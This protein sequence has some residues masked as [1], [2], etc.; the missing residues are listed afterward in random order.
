[1]LRAIKEKTIRRLA[2]EYEIATL[3]SLGA[4]SQGGLEQKYNE[5]KRFYLVYRR[6]VGLAADQKMMINR[7][8]LERGRIR[9]DDPE[10]VIQSMEEMAREL[11][12]REA[13]EQHQ[14]R[15][16]FH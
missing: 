9:V 14:A 10:A 11:D 2:E 6:I 16:P 7:I 12:V 4:I 3:K 15:A 8:L 13:A 1:M 5:I